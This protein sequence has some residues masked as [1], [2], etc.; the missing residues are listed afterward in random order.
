MAPLIAAETGA[1]GFGTPGAR[2]GLLILWCGGVI[3]ALLEGGFGTDPAAA[4][5]YAAALVF[6]LWA[7]LLVTEQSSR[8]LSARRAGATMLATVLATATGLVAA[9]HGASGWVIASAVTAA[10]LLFARGN[11]RW[12]TAAVTATVLPTVLA[13]AAGILDA[14]DAVYV[15]G[16]AALLVPCSILWRFGLRAILRRERLHRSVEAQAAVQAEASAIAA[17]A[18]AQQLERVRRDA[19]PLLERIAT[20][21]RLDAAELAEIEVVEGAIRD[22]LRS[23]LARDEELIA[24][25]G[26]ARRRGVRVLL[27]WDGDPAGTPHPGLVAALTRIVEDARSGSLVIRGGDARRGMSVVRTDEGAVSRVVLDDEGRTLAVR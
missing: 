14:A 26:R 17:R 9:A 2:W 13:A 16:V 24:A 6:D 21:E 3:S 1:A 5:L 23:P 15:L 27:L 22:R 12:A 10:A 11:P 7:L 19:G 18:S 20:A 8:I 4:C 25:I